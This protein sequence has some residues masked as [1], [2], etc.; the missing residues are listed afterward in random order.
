MSIHLENTEWDIE[1]KVGS[2]VELENGV[3]TVLCQD[4]TGWDLCQF[5]IPAAS[6][7]S[8]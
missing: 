3:N 6:T 1:P 7:S 5:R 2:Y 8:R 4:D